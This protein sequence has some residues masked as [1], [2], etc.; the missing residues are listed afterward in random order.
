MILS[1]DIGGSKIA[2]GM[3]KLGDNPKVS[4]FRKIETPEDKESF[5]AAIKNIIAEYKKNNKIDKICVGCAG[6]IDNFGKIARSGNIPLLDN[7]NLP[8]YLNTEFNVEVSI[9]NDVQCFTDAEAIYGAGKNN[10]IVI[11]IMIGTGIGGGIVINKKSFTGSQGFSGEFAY[12][13]LETNPDKYLGSLVSCKAIEKNYFEITENKKTAREIELAAQAGDS[14][15]IEAI[16]RMSKYLE[17]LLLNI[18]TTFNPDAIIIGGGIIDSQLQELLSGRETL[19]SIAK[20]NVLDKL[21]ELRSVK[22]KIEIKLS[23][24]GYNAVLIGATLTLI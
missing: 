1:L 15:S 16:N 22:I 5:L 3:V 24:L 6:F 20:K 9:K 13:L 17:I 4:D 23:E 14:E 8:H 18:I 21:N 7:F 10:N 19:F 11:G 2:F 12:N